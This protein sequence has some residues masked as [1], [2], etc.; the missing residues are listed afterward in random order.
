M[1]TKFRTNLR[2]AVALIL[3]ATGALVLLQNTGISDGDT[4]QVIS[5]VLLGALGIFFTAMYFP[6]KRQWFWVA[7]G[8]GCFSFALSNLVYFIPAL[9]EYYRQVIIFIGVGVSILTIYLHNRMHWWAMFPAG[10]LISLGASQLLEQIYPALD[11]NGVLLIG[12]GLAFLVLFI[13][14]TK[15]GRLKFALLPAVILLALGV[16][17]V[18]GAPYNIDAYL[19]PG[20]ILL[21]GVVLILFTLRKK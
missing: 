6:A 12:L 8:L 1:K 13:V 21:A 9:D 18:I 19:I 14:P 7:L 10:L 20:L 4:G 15:I 17:L 3:I 16:A 5:L 2:R 11:A